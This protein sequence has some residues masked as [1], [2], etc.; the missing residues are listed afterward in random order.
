MPQFLKAGVLSFHGAFI[1][2]AIVLMI[3]YAFYYASKKKYNITQLMYITPAAIFFG[4]AGARLLYVTV[5][6]QLYVEQAE[7][8]RLTDGG[9]SLFGAAAGVLLTVLGWWLITGR[10]H[11]I[12]SVLDTVFASAPVAIFLGRFGSIFSGDCLGGI[13]E[14]ERLTVF[15]VSIYSPVD[16]S[17]HYAVF[18]YE[19]VYC[20]LIFLVIKLAEKK[21]DR[22]GVASYLFVVLYCC[23][24]A[25]FESMR[26]DSMYIGFV[27]IGQAISGVVAIAMFIYMNI[28]L[29]KRSGF[30][31]AYLI[32]YAVFFAAFYTVFYSEFYM[33][34]T[35]KVINTVQIMI[36]CF[37]IMVLNVLTG[38]LYLTRPAGKKTVCR[39]RWETKNAA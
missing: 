35:S 12:T 21:F 18:F 32:S 39:V 9:Y 30:R 28:K 37:V 3:L 26:T 2:V 15:P 27:R 29:V 20:A 17:Y 24:R 34:S 33:Y 1:S 8:W 11:D 14:N 13:V 10:R 19:A 25:L 6:D 36:G 31:Y 16:G 7:K 5:C 22:K 38:W 4:F 23:G